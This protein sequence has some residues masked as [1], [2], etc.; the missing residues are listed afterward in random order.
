MKQLLYVALVAAMFAVSPDADA[1]PDD[2]WGKFQDEVVLAWEGRGVVAAGRADLRG[3]FFQGE[4]PFE[5]AFPQLADVG[6]EREDVVRG[7]LLL[8]DDAAIARAR[9]SAQPLPV[10]MPA[11]VAEAARASRSE[12]LLAEE[13]ADG[14]ERRFLVGVA[15]RLAEHPE[16][17]ADSLEDLRSDLAEVEPTDDP[18]ERARR[19]AMADAAVAELDATVR[20]LLVGGAVPGQPLG[21]VPPEPRD[22]GSAAQLILMLPFLPGEQAIAAGDALF[23]YQSGPRRME[24]EAR[25][26]RARESPM[27]PSTPAEAASR[28]AEL[29]G[30]VREVT[31]PPD[32]DRT[33]VAQG[34]VEAILQEAIALQ[35]KAARAVVQRERPPEP[36]VFDAAEEVER[37]EAHAMAASEAA[38]EAQRL[39]EDDAGRRRAEV[40]RAGADAQV[41]TAELWKS[42]K[43]RAAAAD[44]VM[45]RHQ[46]ALVEIL[47]GIRQ[48]ETRRILDPTRPDPDAVYALLRTTLDGLRTEPAAKGTELRDALTTQSEVRTRVAAE[49]ARLAGAREL[50]AATPDPEQQKEL[51]AAIADWDAALV[52]ELRAAEALEVTAEEERDAVLAALQRSR[53]ARRRLVPWV[54][55]KSRE[56]DGRT[57]LVEIREELSL[58]QPTVLSRVRS[59]YYDLG[60]L[61]GQLLDTT[62]L[63]DLLVGS[64]WTLVLIGA[65]LW[66]RATSPRW[67]QQL[68]ARLRAWRTEL[69]A[70]DLVALHDPATRA[71]VALI[72]LLLGY[73]LID[74]LGDMVSELGF[75]LL[76]YLQ[77]AL[78]RFVLATFDLVVVRPSDFRPA[79]LILRDG[80]WRLA[81]KTVRV[82]AVYLIARGFVSNLL[83]NVLGL[84]RVEAL[85]SSL[86]GL[87]GIAL[88]VVALWAWAPVIRARASMRSDVS[89]G[90]VAW[91]LREDGGNVARV[92]RAVGG[93]GLIGM[94]L[95]SEAGDWITRTRLGTSWLVN[96]VSR[97][98][99]QPQDEADGAAPVTVP[100]DVLHTI[101]LGHP[102]DAERVERPKVDA[103]FDIAWRTWRAE[104]RQ[105]LVAVCGDRGDGKSTTIKRLV[106]RVE[107]DDVPVISH[108]LETGVRGEAAMLDLLAQVLGVEPD[109]SADELVLRIEAGPEVIVVL[110]G[111]ERAYSRMVGGFEALSALLYVMNATS[112]HVFWL[113]TVHRPAWW[114][115]ASAGSMVDVGIFPTV[116]ELQPWTVE[117][118]RALA[119]GRTRAAGLEPDFSSLIRTSALGSDAQVAQERSERT[120]FRLLAEACWGNPHLAL[121]LYTQSLQLVEEGSNVAR[122]RVGPALSNHVIDGLSDVALFVLVAVRLQEQLPDTELPEV[123]NLGEGAV[124]RTVRD[125]LVRGYLERTAAGLRIP[126]GSLP[127]VTRTLRRRHF[128]H[129]GA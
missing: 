66:G 8:L 77:V 54:S 20:R 108:R 79:L 7:R 101:A 59:R 88:V 40:L 121:N 92:V 118:L 95:V 23:A 69:R 28:V 81:R 67:A 115:L 86:F 120:Y 62:V 64:L 35:L 125:L 70:E 68:V 42:A 11:D 47:D 41:R 109:G 22:A 13:A 93:L 113:V 111:L 57:L 105:G 123:T 84:D 16:L 31:F 48:V 87:A 103:A 60:S 97:Y 94:M 129:L 32:G 25:L 15:A 51:R 4:V 91:L 33:G 27:I 127:L 106:E 65:W 56:Q 46:G 119:I 30:R 10:D 117:E 102:T 90:V 82:A 45:S 99:L 26:L 116:I 63:W 52:E 19:A 17:T 36:G 75:V 43:E 6:L 29:E 114:F 122:V 37:A 9:E 128:L 24:A 100:P 126:T 78:Y 12:T 85:V 73:T 55:S 83:W 53:E 124:R 5:V 39:A 107:A 18:D 104:K 34:V 61:P 38:E 14:L 98:R 112:D 1:K 58:L 3:R 74:R 76:V 110:E 89:S 96:A 72:D 80:P 2:S 44:A 71:L 49:R 50:A 21:L